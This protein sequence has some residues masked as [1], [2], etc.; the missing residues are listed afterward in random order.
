MPI[1]FPVQLGTILLCDYSTGFREPEMVKRRPVVV[2]S[3]RPRHRTRLCIVVPLST[4]P[5]R[6]ASPVACPIDL[7]QP[8]P[9][10]FS[11]TALWAKADMLATVSFDRLDLFRTG[12]DQYGKRKYLQPRLPAD[13]LMR[14]RAAMLHALGMETLTVELG[15]LTFTPTAPDPAD[16]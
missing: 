15:T 10:P 9:E 16:R 1:E 6:E 7:A 8:L 11:E 14:I 12:R 4:T 3:P 13:D 2:V 5:P